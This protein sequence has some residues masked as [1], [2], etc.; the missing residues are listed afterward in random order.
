MSWF[1]TESLWICTPSRVLY[2]NEPWPQSPYMYCQFCQWSLISNADYS[3]AGLKS[4]QMRFCQCRILLNVAKLVVR[5]MYMPGTFGLAWGQSPVICYRE[6]WPYQSKL[7]TIPDSDTHGFHA[8]RHHLMPYQ[9]LWNFSF[10]MKQYILVPRV[11]NRLYHLHF[12]RTIQRGRP[13]RGR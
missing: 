8:D 5:Y 9:P 4:Q 11:A 13:K 2:S 3:T 6:L 10:F 7:Q 12:T 1:Y